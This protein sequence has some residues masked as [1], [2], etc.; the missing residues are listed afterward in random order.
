MHAIVSNQISYLVREYS[1]IN[2]NE[3]GVLLESWKSWSFHQFNVKLNLKKVR[4]CYICR[5]CVIISEKSPSLLVCIYIVSMFDLLLQKWRNL[6]LR[7]FQLSQNARMALCFKVLATSL[8]ELVH[9]LRKILFSWYQGIQTELCKH[10]H[11]LKNFKVVGID[12]L[13]NWC[14]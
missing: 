4:I 13:L 5:K 11:F 2:V 7:I 14:H 9:N 12:S 3:F 10:K 8:I 1:M 6:Y